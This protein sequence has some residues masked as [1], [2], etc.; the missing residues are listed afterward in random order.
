VFLA[1]LG[2][3]LETGDDLALA[4]GDTTKLLVGRC[5]MQKAAFALT[6]ALGENCILVVLQTGE[7]RNGT[8]RW[9]QTPAPGL[10]A[11]SSTA[12]SIARA[13]G[14][15][16]GDEWERFGGWGVWSMG[17]NARGQ[18]GRSSATTAADCAVGREVEGVNR[19]S[20]RARSTARAVYK[21]QT[22]S[23]LQAGEGGAAQT[24]AA[25]DDKQIKRAAVLRAEERTD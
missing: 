25:A 13:G 19:R 2:L 22:R 5:T 14:E 17:W 16:G 15:G 4:K 1:Y 20:S 8:A 11:G 18:P 3:V 7:G 23:S 21:E 10:A 12:W 24:L 6:A 9:L